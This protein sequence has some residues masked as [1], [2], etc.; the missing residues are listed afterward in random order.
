MWNFRSLSKK[1]DSSF[2]TWFF[3]LSLPRFS[4]YSWQKENIDN[5]INELY[6]MANTFNKF[7]ISDQNFRANYM[8]VFL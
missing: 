8:N 7:F 1:I 3:H 2:L 5:I 6:A 4:Y